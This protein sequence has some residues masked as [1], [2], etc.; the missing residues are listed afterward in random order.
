MR[1]CRYAGQV[2]FHLE[3]HWNLT[4][5]HM[6]TGMYEQK[7]A[8]ECKRTRAHRTCQRREKKEELTCGRAWMGKRGE[9]ADE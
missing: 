9:G 5:R 4:S 7:D 2:R 6:A 8:D 3:F 1:L